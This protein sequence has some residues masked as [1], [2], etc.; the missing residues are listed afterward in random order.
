STQANPQHTFPNAGSYIVRLTVTDSNGCDDTY[1]LPVD[2]YPPAIPQFTVD[3]PN[4]CEPHSVIFTHT[5]H[6][7]LPSYSTTWYF[8]DGDSATTSPSAAHTYQDPGSYT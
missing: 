3:D 6:P 4:G 1:V 5:S 8:G 2:W 7:F